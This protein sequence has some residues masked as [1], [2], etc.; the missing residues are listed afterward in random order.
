MRDDERV[1]SAAWQARMIAQVHDLAQNRG[2]EQR[3]RTLLCYNG[4]YNTHHDSACM[5]EILEVELK[6][7]IPNETTARRLLA[8]E[9][10]GPYRLGA[11]DE[12]KLHDVYCD[13]GD[14]AIAAAGFAL[15]VRHC[16]G[17]AGVQLKS[18]SSGEGHRHSRRELRLTTDSPMQ[19]ALWPDG[20][21]RDL[22]LEI[23]NGRIV[24]PLFEVEQLRRRAALWLDDEE[25]AEWSVDRIAW[26][27]GGETEMAWEMEVELL[28]GLPANLLDEIDTHLIDHWPVQPQLHS[29]YERGRRLLEGSRRGE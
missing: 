8:Q 7:R 25:I 5:S 22:V 26:R 1:G 3:L 13:T 18:L 17:I 10:L 28:P 4:V 23:V 24:Q 12:Q 14:Q 11:I 15:R 19:P 2:C 27:A 29:K 16:D 6:Y 9:W 20:A 21:A